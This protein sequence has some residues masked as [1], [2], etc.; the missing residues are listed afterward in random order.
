MR[1]GSMLMEVTLAVALLAAA[2]VAI[3]QLLVVASR[4]R[5]N[6]NARSAAIRAVANTMERVMLSE[7]HELTAEDPPEFD[8][9]EADKEWLPGGRLEVQIEPAPS[10]IP[11]KRIVVQVDWEDAAGRRVR[12]IRLVGWSVPTQEVRP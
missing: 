12:P 8:L 4:E 1:R 3:A 2:F 11:Q 5:H 10:D 7:Y 6:A 9:T